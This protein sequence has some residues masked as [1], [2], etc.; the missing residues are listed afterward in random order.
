MGFPGGDYLIFKVEH[1]ADAVQ[2]AWNTMST[3]I[4][5]SGYTPD[6]KPVIERYTSEMIKNHY[7]ELCVTIIA[8]SIS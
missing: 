3:E 5:K 2:N 7:C 8:R 4:K 1:T 6:N